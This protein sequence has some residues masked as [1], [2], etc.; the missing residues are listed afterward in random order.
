MAKNEQRTYQSFWEW[1]EKSKQREYT[2]KTP[3][4]GSDG[5][6]IAKGWARK[7]VF[8][9]DRNRST[10]NNRKKEWDFYQVSNG[11]FMAKKA[12][13]LF[14]ERFLSDIMQISMQSM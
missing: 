3:L 13:S 5:T 6:L 10:P 8:E 2:E 12:F 14:T 11:K 7:N 1:E 4:L 9:Y